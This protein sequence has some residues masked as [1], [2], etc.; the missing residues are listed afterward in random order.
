MN[1]ADP[2][3][4][5]NE[6]VRVITA[7]Q[8]P[9]DP[10][11]AEK[12]AFDKVKIFDLQDLVKAME[13][14]FLYANRIALIGLDSVDHANVVS[15]RTLKTQRSLSISVIVSDRRFSDRRK[16]LMGDATTPGALL[17]GKLLVDTLSELPSGAVVLPGT[18]RLASLE[19]REDQTGRIVFAQDFEIAT[20]WEAVS[21]SRIAK[22]APAS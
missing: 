18:G 7:M 14:L 10:F 19:S 9:V 3:T 17:L 20:D 11:G 13:E 8:L 12:L 21:L 5:L 6:L 16:A 22:V 2:R 15:G 1:L 4:A